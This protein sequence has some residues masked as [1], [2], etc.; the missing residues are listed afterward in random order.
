[1]G[2]SKEYWKRNREAV[3]ARRKARYHNDPEYR[4]RVRAEARKYRERKRAEQG[5][6]KQVVT[7]QGNEYPALTTQ[8]VCDAL[9]IAPARL[10][11]F[12]ATQYLP[13]P[14]VSRPMRLYTKR[15]MHLIAGLEKF[16]RQ[17][18]RYLK[19]PTTN[20]STK[21]Q[22]Q[23]DSMVADIAKRWET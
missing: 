23:L 22:A 3:L 4:E 12:H 5:K 16:L 18:A 13:P 8:E 9:E 10:K 19:G 11:H 17:N 7:I 21:V 2:Y 14:L 20:R 15:Q 1:M 6:D